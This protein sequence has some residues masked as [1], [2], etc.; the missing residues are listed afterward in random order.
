M[1]PFGPAGPQ[2]PAGTPATF[3][4]GTLFYL[5]SGSPA[6]TGFIFVG[7]TTIHVSPP[8][9]GKHDDDDNDDT[10]A[11]RVDVYKKK[12]KSGNSQQQEQTLKG[13]AFAFD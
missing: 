3:P 11:I 10:L 9:A 5:V 7:S 2:G 13:S 6:P 12:L 8:K 4:Q 1:G